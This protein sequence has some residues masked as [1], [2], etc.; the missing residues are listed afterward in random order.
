M[1]KIL[2]VILFLAGLFIGLKL[3]LFYKM[4]KLSPEILK[5]AVIVDVRKPSEYETAHVEGAINL[6]MGQMENM[7]SKLDKSKTYITYCDQGLRSIK[8]QKELKNLGF[9]EV[10]NGGTSVRI[11]K[12]LQ[13][14]Q[15]A[16]N[17]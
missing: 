1:K 7:I 5:D 15:N 8:G 12:S 11:N 2:L 16:N 3:F 14:P 9:S 6:P 4:D 13:H 10:L 17:K